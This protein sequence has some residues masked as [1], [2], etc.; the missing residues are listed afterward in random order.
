VG[1]WQECGRINGPDSKE[2]EN[3]RWK[4]QKTNLKTKFK[5]KRVKTKLHKNILLGW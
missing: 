3:L 2:D 5:A 1:W 4:K